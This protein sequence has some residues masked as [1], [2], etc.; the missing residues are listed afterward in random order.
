MQQ[1]VSFRWLFLLCCRYS[2]SQ[3]FAALS[4]VLLL[5]LESVANCVKKQKVNLKYHN[6][7]ESL[8]QSMPLCVM[9]FCEWVELYYKCM[10]LS[11][12]KHIC[13]ISAT[14]SKSIARKLSINWSSLSCVVSPQFYLMPNY[15]YSRRFALKTRI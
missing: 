9:F 2:K 7:P 6:S 4:L 11:Y 8:V 12:A 1:A 10:H 15:I 3:T 13:N 14:T 5:R